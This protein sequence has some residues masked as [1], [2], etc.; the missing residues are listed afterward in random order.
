MKFTEFYS[1]SSP[2]LSFE[3][4]PPKSEE[5]IP[6]TKALMER[7]SKLGPDYMTVTY[8]AGGGT[9]SFTRDLVSYIQNDLGKTAVAHLTCVSHTVEEVDSVLDELKSSGVQNV[10][11]LRGDPPA[12]ADKFIKTE[13]GFSCA[14]DLC[15]H[16]KKRGDFSI[17]VAGYPEV[18]Q[19]AESPERDLE[20]LKEKVDAG[21]EVIITQ[22]FFSA[23]MYF[24]FR[25]RA[26]SIGIDVPIIPGIM[27]IAKVSQVKRFTSMC[28]ASIPK[29]LA[30]QLE[31]IQD[32]DE[33]VVKF[34]TDY[35]IELARALLDGGAPGLH[36]YTLN[37]SQ[38]TT[39]IVKGLGLDS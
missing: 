16:I 29:E 10:L 5:F 22:L 30:D 14:R 2:V 4:F 9:R 35:A 27:P 32:N 24:S 31:R 15:A 38:Q 26:Q 21:A 23:E 34:G 19:E 12:G 36:I 6:K 33:A 20:Y 13:G 7:L 11:A 17:A 39:P 3:F 18:H 1:Q 37:K 28:G 8:G 25:D